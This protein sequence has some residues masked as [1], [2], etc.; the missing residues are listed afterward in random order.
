M[1]QMIEFVD[2][3]LNH[4]RGQRKIEHFRQRQKLFKGS[5]YNFQR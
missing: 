5:E 1:T 4:S 3:A 2:K